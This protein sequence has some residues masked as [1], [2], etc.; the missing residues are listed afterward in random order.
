MYDNVI[1]HYSI[2]II[3][4]INVPWAYS[5]SNPVTKVVD[6]ILNLS[7]NCDWIDKQMTELTNKCH[8]LY[9]T[10]CAPYLQRLQII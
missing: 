6:N 10:S 5:D 9:T 1:V 2:M 8:E 3:V 7:G 4:N